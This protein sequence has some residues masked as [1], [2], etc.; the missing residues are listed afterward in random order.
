VVLAGFTA[1]AP[2]AIDMYLPA[3]PPLAADLGVSVDRAAQSISVFLFGIAG[4]Q[5]VAGPLSDR[6][7]RKPLVT[8]GLLLFLLSAVTAALTTSFAVLLGARLVQAFGACSVMVAGR[9]VVRDMLDETE[10]ARFFSLLALIG[11]LAPVLAPLIG[12]AVISV[13]DWRAIFWVM[14][15]F[16]LLMVLGLPLLHESRSH[17]TA[18]NARAEHPFR[19]YGQLLGNRR[20]LGY[21][22][23][24][25]FNSAGF[26]AYVAN[27]SVVLVSGYGLSPT[28]FSLLFG[29]NSI[30]LV[31]AAQLN[32]AML[33]S[34]DLSQ[35]LRMS[36][37]NAVI[38]S[39]LLLVFATSGIGG[40]WGLSAILFFVVGS[41]SP[42]QAN[43]MA[44]GL[45]IDPLRAGSAA[46]LF[47]AAT[48]AAGA[49]ASAVA[50]ALYD[51][52]ARGLCLVISASLIGVFLSIR[53][54]ILRAGPE[55]G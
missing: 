46:A 7:G 47:G 20:L 19:A 49:I 14:A 9:A 17:E 55:A 21:L 53:L 42:V 23:A 39:V 30:A 6:F 34:R 18:A 41:V 4:G 10:S 45:S 27:S 44:G 2:M 35:M 8:V 51:G 22:L 28:Q 40:L 16:G 50:G 52:T 15:A 29:V 36:A 43:T 26:F 12:A 54:F 3:L 11:G 33:K 31:G 1:L 48:F 24:A 32:R 5:L 25:M 13:A 37:R 38:L